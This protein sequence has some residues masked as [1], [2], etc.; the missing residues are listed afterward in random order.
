MASNTTPIPFWNRLNV[1]S[2]Y[3]FRGAALT[4]LVVLG[5]AS[6]LGKLP[7]LIG[8]FF[9]V[10]VWVGIYRYAF[11]ILVR[12]ANGHMEAPEIATHTDTGVVLRFFVL[13]FVY[14][15]LYA[16]SSWYGG[17]LLGVLVMLALSLLLPGAIISLAMDGDLL[18]A[19]NPATALAIMSRIGAPYFAAFGLLFVIQISAGTAGAWLSHYMPGVLATVL[20]TTATL[21]GLFATFHLMGY[22]VFQ[23][24]NALGFEPGEAHDR[25]PLRTRDSDLMDAVQTNITQGNTEAARA[26]LEEAM[27][28][29]AVPLEAHELYRKLLNSQG[30]NTKLLEH[31]GPYLNVLLLEN[32]DRRALGLL[33]ESL[34]TDPSFTPHQAE[35]GDRLAQ[36]ARELGQSRLACDLWLAMLKRWP[37]HAARSEWALS[38]AAL[39]VQRDLVMQARTTL[40]GAA[41]GLE[42]EQQ[43]ATLTNALAQLPKD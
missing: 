36:R 18:L 43:Q 8:L 41:H 34:D 29:R 22:L 6:L 1:I 2:T 11:E 12:T 26:L 10:V 28:E 35:D 39:L 27:R 33:R 23:Y 31:A 24:H 38:A 7:G 21:W 25:S 37:R 13:I 17:A 20:V 5:L 16:A 40:E 15:L 4:S 30:E 9:T 3:P 42:D 14:L 19:L 32:N